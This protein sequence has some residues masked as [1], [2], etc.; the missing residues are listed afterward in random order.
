MSDYSKKYYL[1]ALLAVLFLIIIYLF[2]VLTPFAIAFII[3]YLVNPF[4]IFFDK[5]LNQTFSSFISVLIFV[6]G[7]ISI[8]ILILPIITFQIQNLI[9][10]IP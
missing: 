7:C 5:Y 8:L 3:A 1:Y 6:L 2:E 4:K 9:I 10:I